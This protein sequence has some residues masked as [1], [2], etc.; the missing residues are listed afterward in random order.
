[1]YGCMNCWIIHRCVVYS[2]FL[3]SAGQAAEEAATMGDAPLRE[4]AVTMAGHEGEADRVVGRMMHGKMVSDAIHPRVCRMMMT[5]M[6]TMM[7]MTMTHP[8]RRY[9]L[10][11]LQR[12]R[13]LLPLLRQGQDRPPVEP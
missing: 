12:L 11:S 3:L 7:M 9:P 10:R 6:M 4:A 8:S 2:S 13:R 5:M 1:M